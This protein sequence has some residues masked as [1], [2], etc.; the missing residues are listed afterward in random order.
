MNIQD[1]TTTLRIDRLRKAWSYWL[2]SFPVL[3][4]VWAVTLTFSNKVP[5]S[6]SPSN[7]AARG[8]PLRLAAYR[9][10]SPAHICTS[11]HRLWLSVNKRMWP[12]RY[13]ASG[14]P[15][16]AYK[17]FLE[18]RESNVHAHFAWM[19]PDTA[20]RI[21]LPECLKAEWPNVISGGAV[22]IAEVH[23]AAGWGGYMVKS[24]LVRAGG[25]RGALIAP[26]DDALQF[27]SSP[28]QT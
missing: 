14:L 1:E 3:G 19:Q 15:V 18:H 11:V 28:A 12:K 17:G 7:V 8:A 10:L 22:D 27:L 6:A 13:I 26:D 21:L 5:G 23:D 16:T 9:T 24:Q 2:C 4:K 25:N 20:P